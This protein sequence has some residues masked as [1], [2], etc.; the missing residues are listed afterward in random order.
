MSQPPPIPQLNL[1]APSE[2]LLAHGVFSYGLFENNVRESPGRA[3]LHRHKFHE[4]IIILDGSDVYSADFKDYAITSPCVILVP[5]GTCHQWQNSKNL[6]GVVLA[7][8]LEFLGLRSRSEGVS[9]LLRS[10]IP[11]VTAL[12]DEV[13][14]A[15]TPHLKRI[16]SEWENKLANRATAI[17]AALTLILIDLQRHIESQQSSHLVHSS[18]A[19]LLYADFL[20]I[21]DQTW[22][23]SPRPKD[24]ADALRISPDHLSATLR[25]VT[26]SNTSNLISERILLEAK[27]LLAHSRLSIAEVA[28]ATGFEDPSYFARF[29]KRNAG[30]T[31]KEFREQF[32]IKHER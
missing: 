12:N 9:K 7:F 17:H 3:T 8:D 30:A 5:S 20:E 26:G 11:P 24:L 1:H 10:S 22:K 14:E 21:L 23:T 13:L 18:K 31:P 27:R 15:L 28:Y 2:D 16:E 6:K 29:F 32:E 4:V 19:Q 25:E